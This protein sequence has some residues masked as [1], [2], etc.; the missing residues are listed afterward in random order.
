MVAGTI[1]NNRVSLSLPSREGKKDS[2]AADR[3]HNTT[4]IRTMLVKNVV[5]R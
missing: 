5:V 1:R 4:N 2:S 3:Y